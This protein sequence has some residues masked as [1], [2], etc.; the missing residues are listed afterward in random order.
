[1]IN[2]EEDAGGDM[3]GLHDEF[4]WSQ[5]DIIT[6]YNHLADAGLVAM[7]VIYLIFAL[8]LD[9]LLVRLLHRTE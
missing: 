8:R 2:G 5:H 3:N 4:G 7:V 1:M 9:R 6:T